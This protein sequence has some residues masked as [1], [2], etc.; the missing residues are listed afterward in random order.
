MLGSAGINYDNDTSVIYMGNKANP[1]YKGLVMIY[2]SLNKVCLWSVP[3]SLEREDRREKRKE[4][5]PLLLSDCF[6]SLSRCYILFLLLDTTSVCCLMFFSN[7]I[8]GLFFFL[9]GGGLSVCLPIFL[10]LSIA[11]VPLVWLTVIPHL[12][13]H[14]S[15]LLS[16]TQC[17]CIYHLDH[18]FSFICLSFFQVF[19]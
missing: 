5:K 17:T 10:Y 14:S 6:F 11:V 16:E 3:K 2:I 1:E 4:R 8:H 18:R 13:R 9:G 15:C 7:D 12:S 19:S